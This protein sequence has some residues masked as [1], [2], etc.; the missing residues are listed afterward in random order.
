MGAAM[1]SGADD[2]EFNQNVC[3]CTDTSSFRTDLS[4]PFERQEVVA[5]KAIIY[6]IA[7]ENLTGPEG[8]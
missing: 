4:D 2:R 5:A 7:R 1:T 3:E 6:Q 8:L